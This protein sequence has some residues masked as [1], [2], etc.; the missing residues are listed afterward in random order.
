[1]LKIFRKIR[2]QLISENKFNKYI[3][4]AIGEI[5]L[6]LIGILL[7]LAISDWNDARI[8]KQA[9]IR[10]L[11]ELKKGI[12]IDFDTITVKQAEVN[13]S[14][15]DLHFLQSLIKNKDYPYSK[16]LDTLFGV[17]YGI[18][19]LSPNSAFYEDLKATGLKLI[20]DETIRLQIV[21]LFENNYKA[22]NWINELEMSIN[23]VNR[24]Y[25]LNNFY[26]LTFS[27]YAT[28]NNFKFVWTDSY[29]HNI[30]DYRL[31]TLEK[32]HV[33][34]YDKTLKAIKTLVTTIDNY[35]E[36]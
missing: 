34:Q 11:I 6:V 13:K 8:D 7:A 20:K 12:L 35:L 4:Y 23:D 29:Y 17:V 32:N 19:M 36:K 15:A 3:L 22:L 31:I 2:Q 18:R 33:I 16:E 24:T 14:I 28:P 30:I 27:K 26:D 5:F 10:T 21:Q 1:M 25:Y 9:E